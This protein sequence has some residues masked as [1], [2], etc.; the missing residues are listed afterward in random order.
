MESGSGTG[1]VAPT[2]AESDGEGISHASPI[3]FLASLAGG[4]VPAFGEA[5]EMDEIVVGSVQLRG[6][7]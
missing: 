1:F 7:W 4:K 6:A 2:S 5:V 3:S